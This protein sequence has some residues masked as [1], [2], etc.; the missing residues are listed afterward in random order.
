MGN[1][2]VVSVRAI[3]AVYL[4]ARFFLC[5]KSIGCVYTLRLF[6]PDWV[7]LLLSSLLV[8]VK[9]AWT[10]TDCLRM[11]DVERPEVN[12]DGHLFNTMISVPY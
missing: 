2:T 4:A 12:R 1:P 8:V 3:T 11:F 9:C 5:C 7:P 10:E 6:E